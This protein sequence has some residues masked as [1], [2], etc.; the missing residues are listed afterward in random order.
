MRHLRRLG[1]LKSDKKKQN[2][3]YRSKAAIDLIALKLA[4]DRAAASG[5]RI[6]TLDDLEDSTEFF[7]RIKK[8][9]TI[10]YSEDAQEE[11]IALMAP[12]AEAPRVNSTKQRLQKFLIEHE[13]QLKASA[14]ER[15]GSTKGGQSPV[16]EFV[17]IAIEDVAPKRNLKAW[18]S[19]SAGQ[20]AVYALQRG[21]G[22]SLWAINLIEATMDHLE[23]M[24]WGVDDFARA[25]VVEPTPWLPPAVEEP[26]EP[27][28]TPLLALVPD[29][30]VSTLEITSTEDVIRERYAEALL[31]ILKNDGS[32]TSPEILGRLDKLAGIV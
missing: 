6:P 32:G 25:E 18:R 21:K 27:E 11:A 23:G 14:I 24:R 31:E 1:L 9:N 12:S 20:Q 29:E 15:R 7:T 17:N 22:V 13:D 19:V 8:S 3:R 2:H 16:V 4:Q 28:P 10:Q 30:N 26:S 5:E